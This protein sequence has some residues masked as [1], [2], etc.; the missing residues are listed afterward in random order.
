[1]ATK[2]F[3]LLLIFA[4]LSSHCYSG[5]IS[6]YWGQNQQEGTLADTCKTGRFEYVIISFLCVFG[7][8][9][10]PQLDLDDHCDPSTK[11]CVG[12]A[13]D[14]RSCQS[15]G[16]K[17][18]LSIGGGDGVYI[19]VSSE[20]AKEFADYLWNNYLGGN[21]TDRPFGDAVLDGIDF[22]IEGGSPSHYDELAG[23][24]KNYTSEKKVYLTAAPQCPFPDVYVGQALSTG[25]FDYVWMQ[26][27]NNYCEY[28]G[29]ASDVKATFDEWSDG[30]PATKFFLGLPAAPSGASSGF[31]PQNVL[32]S[33]ILPLIKKADK[34]GGVMLWSK[35]YDDL[36]GY[37]S[38]I[39]SHV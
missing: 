23:H 27:Y 25:L 30:V 31:I 5:S 16:V 26:F 13:D 33:Q 39:K 37:S 7:N 21:S 9:Q 36:T 1:M 6:I 22:D 34:Y 32:I 15:R 17:V 8:N 38:S 3:V 2:M 18:L 11:G 19:L 24:L 20:E 35:Y 12:L 4:V 10:I 14:I 28:K 29:N